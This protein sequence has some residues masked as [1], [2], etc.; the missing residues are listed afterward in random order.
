MAKKKT[1]PPPGMGRRKKQDPFADQIARESARAGLR[2]PELKPSDE[3]D[4]AQAAQ[5]EKTLE[6]MKAQGLLVPD[7]VKPWEV[8]HPEAHKRTKSEPGVMGR[9]VLFETPEALREAAMAYFK[10]TYEN[11][12][13]K[14]EFKD[15][16]IRNIP[17]RPLFTID[18][19]RIYLGVGESFW[20]DKRAATKGDAD[21]S[22]VFEWVDSVIRD[23]KIKGAT[24]GF[25][26]ENIVAREY[27]K[28]HVV[29]EVED[30][31]KSVDDLFPPEIDLGEV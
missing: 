3:L 14:A 31:R 9:P 18:G 11:P 24:L 26:K 4:E 2:I 20:R 12:E 19:L 21:F 13:Y 8:M 17:T 22:A 28:E 1:P 23:N 27:V 10:Y 6:A 15:G 30:K 7:M 25:F 29:T 5:D 16:L